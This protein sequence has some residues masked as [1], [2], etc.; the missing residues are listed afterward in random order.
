MTILWGVIGVFLMLSV[1]GLVN[2]LVNTF[3][4]NTTVPSVGNVVPQMQ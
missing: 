2:I 3:W 1:W 4:L